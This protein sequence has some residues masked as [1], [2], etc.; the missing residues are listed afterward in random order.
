MIVK[1]QRLIAKVVEKCLPKTCWNDTF[2][3]L[4]MESALIFHRHNQNHS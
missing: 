2:K 1:K 3:N 4:V